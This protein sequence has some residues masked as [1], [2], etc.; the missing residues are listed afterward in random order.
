MSAEESPKTHT[1]AHAHTAG[2]APANLFLHLHLSLIN[3]ASIS[4]L[5]C[6]TLM[7]LESFFSLFWQ[8][9]SSAVNAP[10]LVV[11]VVVVFLL[12]NR[13]AL[14]CSALS[15]RRGLNVGR[16]GEGLNARLS[17]MFCFQLLNTRRR[18]Y[19]VA[20]QRCVS[21]GWSCFISFWRSKRQICVFST[22]G[23]FGDPQMCLGNLE[24]FFSWFWN[25]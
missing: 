24:I 15:C 20:S 5:W 13:A 6:G 2:G 4:A 23:T 18:D 19:G 7:G 9:R 21:D 22:F 8:R 1:H 17:A 11:V 16:A 12:P 25:I 14:S 10:R 3:T